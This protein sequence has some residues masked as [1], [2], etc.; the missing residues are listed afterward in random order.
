[1]RVLPRLNIDLFKV[2]EQV[3]EFLLGDTFT[4]V[5]NRDSELDET[6]V[7]AFVLVLNMMLL[8][9]RV[10]GQTLKRVLVDCHV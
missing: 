9:M 10:F 3:F 1:V 6:D 5:L 4:K 2:D 7:L 8:L